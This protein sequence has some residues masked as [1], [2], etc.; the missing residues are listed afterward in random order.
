MA[1][2]ARLVINIMS[3]QVR[4]QHAHNY[5]RLFMDNAG[6]HLFDRFDYTK[7]YLYTAY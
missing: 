3:T 6:N 4:R 1:T 7:L 5:W 2:D